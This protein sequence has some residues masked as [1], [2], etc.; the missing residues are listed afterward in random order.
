MRSERLFPRRYQVDNSSVEALRYELKEL[1]KEAAMFLRRAVD[2]VARRRQAE[3]SAVAETA[4]ARVAL[5]KRRGDP[6]WKFLEEQEQEIGRGIRKKF[7][8]FGVRLVDAVRYSPLM[9]QADELEVR[10]IVRGVSACVVGKRYRY[11]ASQ[12]VSEEDKVFGIE[13]ATHEES[14]SSLQHCLTRLESLFQLLLEKMDLIAPAPEDLTRAI[15][16]SQVPNIQRYRSNTAFIMMQINAKIP[17]LE[18]I[19]NSIKDVFKEFGIEAVRSDEIEHSETITQRILDEISTSEFLIADLTGERP[20]VYYEVG[21]AHAAGKRPI[22]YRKKGTSLHFDLVV[23][24][25]PEYTNTTDLKGQ[26]RKRLTV[27]TNREPNKA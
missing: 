4:E 19:K 8:E 3:E 11:H 26:L 27:M 10:N 5:I 15:V 13:P 20:S 21:Y 18:D 25:V 2:A 23:H 17:E 22:L 1:C 9:E 7:V 12:V 6:D 16:S 24:N 14:Y